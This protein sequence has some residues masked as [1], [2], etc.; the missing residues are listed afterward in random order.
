MEIQG[1]PNTLR[2]GESKSNKIM[3]LESLLTE[4]GD[5]LEDDRTF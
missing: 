4:L 5:M 1:E 2:M 3:K